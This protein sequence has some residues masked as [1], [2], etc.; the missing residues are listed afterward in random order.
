MM[1]CNRLV[2]P[3]FVEVIELGTKPDARGVLI[4]PV[5]D[6]Q[7]SKGRVLNLHVVTAAPNVVRGNHVHPKRRE[8]ICV[9][10]GHFLASFRN[11]A[12]GQ[13]Y[14]LEVADGRNVMFTVEPGTAHALKNIGLS[15][16][17]LLCYADVPFE[18]ADIERCALLS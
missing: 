16:G 2:S 7:I 1:E 4:E 11:L 15:V 6:Q 13:T 17:Y 10:G 5:D 18:E 8:T 14:E 12:T 9:L 3:D